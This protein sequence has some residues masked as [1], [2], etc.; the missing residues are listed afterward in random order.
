MTK[1]MS[2]RKKT[3]QPRLDCDMSDEAFI[4]DNPELEAR[5]YDWCT[6]KQIEAA[7]YGECVL[8][9]EDRAFLRQ[10]HAAV[11]RMGEG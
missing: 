7:E 8:S 1:I 4:P 10:V 2:F 3:R 9:D 5:F 11:H 6:R